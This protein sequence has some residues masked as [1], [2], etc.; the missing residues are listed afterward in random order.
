MCEKPSEFFHGM[1]WG[2]VLTAALWIGIAAVIWI[3]L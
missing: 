1:A 2:V 3:S